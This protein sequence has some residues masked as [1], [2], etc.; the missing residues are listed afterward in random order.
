MFFS[1][2]PYI[3]IIYP[4]CNH[5]PFIEI[6]YNVYEYTRQK[7]CWCVADP[8]LYFGRRN[9]ILT[10][11]LYGKYGN[12]YSLKTSKSYFMQKNIIASLDLFKVW[13]SLN[14]FWEWRFDFPKDCCD[15]AIVIL[16]RFNHFAETIIFQKW[17]SCKI[18]YRSIFQND[19][20]RKKQQQHVDANIVLRK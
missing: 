16:R 4:I 15:Q 5:V 10:G 3:H 11:P 8:K 17:R 1:P 19:K 13:L 12:K 20:K 18:V 2:C 9:R 6:V 14:K 7:Y